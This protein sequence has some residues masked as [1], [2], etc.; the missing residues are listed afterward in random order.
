MAVRRD[1]DQALLRLAPRLLDGVA[2]AAGADTVWNIGRIAFTPGV[3]NVV[4][5]GA[6]LT[7]EVRDPDA[8]RLDAIEAALPQL[9]DGAD[10]AG[11]RA[12]GARP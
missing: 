5:A 7:L 2:R 8:A 3:A 12:G 6:E 10:A 4:P 1:A 9:L 11:R